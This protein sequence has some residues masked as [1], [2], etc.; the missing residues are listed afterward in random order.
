[1]KFLCFCVLLIQITDL[2]AQPQG[3]EFSFVIYDQSRSKVVNCGDPN[4]Q[5]WLSYVDDSEWGLDERGIYDPASINLAH[6]KFYDS[7]HCRQILTEN[8]SI[9]DILSN[10]LNLKQCWYYQKNTDRQLLTV[11]RRDPYRPENVDTMHIYLD[12]YSYAPEIMNKRGMPDFLFFQK[13]YFTWSK[14]W[15]DRNR[16]VLENMFVAPV[17]TEY[18]SRA[19]ASTEVPR[20]LVDSCDVHFK[21]ASDPTY[22]SAVEIIVSGTFVSNGSCDDYLPLWRLEKLSSDRWI[23]EYSQMEQMDCGFG[24][25]RVVD[26]KL[27]VF[28]LCKPGEK[29]RS[30]KPREYSMINKLELEQGTYRLIIWDYYW[31]PH[32]SESFTL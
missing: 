2:F 19:Y 14:L 17:R 21:I 4:Y 13:G 28:W 25:R 6:L 31:F 29:H 16:L 9:Q 1:M 3:V 26:E 5:A 12:G 32:Y 22:N 24:M 7:L 15:F 20:D 11:V 30:T 27:P 18:F 8:D 23:E 10:Q